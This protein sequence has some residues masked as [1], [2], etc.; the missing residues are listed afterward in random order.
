M[1]HSAR[2]ALRRTIWRSIYWFVL[3]LL[4]LLAFRLFWGYQ[5]Q[6]RLNA[7]LA[8]L[9]A[10]HVRYRPAQFPDPSNIPS[11]QNAVDGLLAGPLAYYGPPSSIIQ[12]SLEFQGA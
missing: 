3:P 5:A 12:D 1:R 10:M 2:I 8:K 6:R 11:N 4:F 9:D 7:T